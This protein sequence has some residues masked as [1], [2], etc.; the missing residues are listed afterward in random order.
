MGCLFGG[1]IRGLRSRKNGRLW[2]GVLA[3]PLWALWSWCSWEGRGRGVE[4]WV[5]GFVAGLVAERV[6][7]WKMRPL[8]LLELLKN[9]H[10]RRTRRRRP[11]CEAGAVGCELMWKSFQSRQPQSQPCRNRQPH[12]PFSL[13]TTSHSMPPLTSI[14]ARG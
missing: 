8:M 9:R 3:G 4:G 14:N 11:C 5:V 10:Q 1:G 13:S 6:E 2:F 12:R 7:D